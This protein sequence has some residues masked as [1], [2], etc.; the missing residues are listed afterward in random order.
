M[1]D[2]EGYHRDGY[3]I[4]SGPD[5]ARLKATLSSA[6]STLALAVL[7]KEFAIGTYAKAFTGHALQDLVDH[8][9]SEETGN[10]VSGRFYRVFPTAPELI[11]AIADPAVLNWVRA[12]GI[13]APVAGTMPIV[14]LDRPSDEVHRTP[15]HQDWWFSLLSPNCVSVWFPLGAL[16]TDMGLLEVVPGSHRGGAI[17][18]AENVKSNNKPFRPAREWLDAAFVPVELADDAILIFSQY[19]LHR[20]GF[21]RSRHVRMSVQ[22]RYNDLATMERARSLA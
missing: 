17:T 11:A 19:L 7:A 20:S 2:V 16:N 22:L 9:V 10:E 3:V 21:N 1:I 8:V 15:P 13:V 14:R 12:L 5:V 18:F 6:L 4:V